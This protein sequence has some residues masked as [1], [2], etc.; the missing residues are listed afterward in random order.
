MI[1]TKEV[2]VLED[3]VLFGKYQLKGILGKGRAGTVF[4]AVHMELEEFRAIKRVSKS[5]VDYSR[6]KREALILKEL[7]HPGIP[8]I[9]DLEEDSEYSYLIEEY[10]EGES[11]YDLIHNQGH[12]T[13]AMTVRYGIQICQIVNYLHSAGEIP[14]LYL[15]LQ[16]KNLLLCNE[17]VKLVDFDHSAAMDQ[18]NASS[19]RYG[20]IG[21]AAPEQY[22]T[23]VLLDERTD[24][25]AIGVTLIYLGTGKY[26]E[27]SP[28]PGLCGWSL[29]FRE[30]VKT[31]LDPDPDKRY[32]SAEELCRDLIRLDQKTNGVSKLFQKNQIS[33]LTIAFAGGKSGVGT[34]HLAIGFSVYLR[35]SGYPSLYEEC[36]DSGAV[37]R[38][39]LIFGARADRFGRVRIRGCTMKPRYGEAVV[40]ERC[41]SPVVIKDYGSDF[42]RLKDTSDADCI[43]LVCDGSLWEA[44][45]AGKAVGKLDSHVCT[46]VIFNHVA[47][48]VKVRKDGN[49]KPEF[50]FKAPW[51]PDPFHPEEIHMKF[52]ETL[53]NSLEIRTERGGLL[54]R[55]K[56]AAVKAEGKMLLGLLGRNRW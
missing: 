45:E 13:A 30:I 17:T 50:C 18:A 16:P 55:L 47:A 23:D 42:T 48:G 20:T 32:Q 15:D 52:Y 40:L 36:N 31:C 38:L 49:L 53:M 37:R 28:S 25:Y 1:F 19:Q 22:R 26:P 11:F 24:I 34:T 9:Y 35:L 12:L 54:R 39:A 3:T 7:R 27:E 46:R 6:F 14:I 33:S 51:Q 2:C 29:R 8:I 4:L 56:R 10:L 41:G 43:F 44:G 21:W 5:Y